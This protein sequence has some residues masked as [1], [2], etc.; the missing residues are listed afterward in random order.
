MGKFTQKRS[1][2]KW[3]KRWIKRLSDN[4]ILRREPKNLERASALSD[5][6]LRFAQ[7]DSRTINRFVVQ[8]TEGRFLAG[9]EGPEL[10]IL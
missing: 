3:V 6:I 4:V 1:N 5:E 8:W 9:G 7:N 10:I 2:Q